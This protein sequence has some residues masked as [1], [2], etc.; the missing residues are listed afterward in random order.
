[1]FAR[2]ELDVKELECRRPR[3][4]W[5]CGCRERYEQSVA[6]ASPSSPADV[7][8]FYLRVDIDRLLPVLVVLEER[9]R[10]F[11]MRP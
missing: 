6:G 11:S 9:N 10:R 2:E 8:R 5:N 1:M 3:M 4:C 7:V